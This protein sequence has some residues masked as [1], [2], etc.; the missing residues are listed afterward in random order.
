MKTGTEGLGTDRQRERGVSGSPRD[1]SHQLGLVIKLEV[2][3][4]LVGLE[5]IL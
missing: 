3:D 4:G 2:L 1:S 5:A